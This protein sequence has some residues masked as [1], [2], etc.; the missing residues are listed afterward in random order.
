LK[1]PFLK[2]NVVL[3]KDFCVPVLQAA[4]EFCD[5]VGNKKLISVIKIPFEDSFFR[6][7]VTYKHRKTCELTSPTFAPCFISRRLKERVQNFAS[8]TAAELT[9]KEIGNISIEEIKTFNF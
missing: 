4:D 1:R 3:K 6:E 5:Y 2:S 8:M 7:T 9:R